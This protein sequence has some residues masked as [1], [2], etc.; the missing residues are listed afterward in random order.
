MRISYWSSDV[1]SSDLGDWDSLFVPFPSPRNKTRVARI[2]CRGRPADPSSE[3]PGDA[4]AGGV[5]AVATIGEAGGECEGRVGVQAMR[6]GA[7]DRLRLA[8]GRAVQHIAGPAGL[9]RH[10]GIDHRHRRG[11]ARACVAPRS[12]EHTSEL[13]S[14]MRIS[15]AD[16][17]LKN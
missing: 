12:E 10:R 4:D 17:G 15:Y 13:Q 16:F 1:C 11:A 9:R 3:L 8:E 14:L 2:G 5:V 6:D 7:A